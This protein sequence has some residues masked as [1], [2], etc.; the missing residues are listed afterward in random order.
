MAV[1]TYPLA[2][3]NGNILTAARGEGTTIDKGYRKE[4]I[5]DVVGLERHECD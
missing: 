1:T 5:D 2:E 3:A 4:S